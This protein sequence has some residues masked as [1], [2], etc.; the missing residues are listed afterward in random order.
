MAAALAALARTVRVVHGA[1]GVRG[2]ASAAGL[3]AEWVRRA[4]AHK[5]ARSSGP[6]GQAVN[7]INSKA[8][9]RLPVHRVYAVLD[10]AAVGR[11]RAAQAH[12]INASDELVVASDQH[13]SQKDNLAEC[14]RRLLGWLRAAQEPPK[15]RI[16]TDKPQYAV[17]KIKRDKQRRSQTKKMR[18]APIEW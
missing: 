3:C 6:G 2:A 16:P 7:K 8:Q 1:E 17:D 13:R 14:V 9:V 15:E 4:S 11:L 12:R 5:F 10:D 18:R